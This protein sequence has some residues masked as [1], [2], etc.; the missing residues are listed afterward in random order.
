MSQVIKRS[1]AMKKNKELNSSFPRWAL[2]FKSIHKIDG[3]IDVVT[4]GEVSDL[5]SD[6]GSKSQGKEA[7]STIEN[8]LKC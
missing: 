5:L 4:N 1:R 8:G 2:T 6:L 3:T 7:Q